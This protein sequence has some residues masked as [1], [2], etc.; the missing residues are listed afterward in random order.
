[1]ST[2]RST[3][4]DVMVEGEHRVALRAVTLGGAEDVCALDLTGRR[5]GPVNCWMNARLPPSTTQ[6]N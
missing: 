2:M 3:L 5:H 6:R 4:V 1:M